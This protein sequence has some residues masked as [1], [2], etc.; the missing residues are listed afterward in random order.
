MKLTGPMHSD[1]ASG[2]F[3][4]VLVASVWKGNAYMRLR[5]IPKNPKSDGQAE[6]R[7]KLGVVGY[8]ESFILRPTKANPTDKSQFWV[9]A[10]AAAP[11][12][13]SWISYATRSQVGTGASTFDATHTAYAAVSST[14]KGYYETAGANM[15]LSDFTLPYGAYGT[16]TVG[17]MVYD[18]LNFAINALAYPAPAGG[19]ASPTPTEL[20]DFVTYCQTAI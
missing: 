6:A 7:T 5:V 11:A 15:G 9:D 17:E 18:L 3:A 20:A 8:A 2:S 12:G 14:P 19:I 13:Q 16:I 4:K 10:V 1:A